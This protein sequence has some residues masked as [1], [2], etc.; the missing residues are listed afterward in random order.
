MRRRWHVIAELCNEYGLRTGAEIGVAEG[1]FTAALLSLCPKVQLW[2]IDDYAPGYRTWMGAEWSQERQ[3][4]NKRA[5]AEVLTQFPD[6][7]RLMGLSSLD[8][9][10]EFPDA[11]LDFVFIDAD[12]SYEAVS[13]DIA[14]WRR[15]IRPGGWMTGHD[16]DREKFPGVIRAVD[17]CFSPRVESDFVWMA[18]I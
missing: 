15:R 7:L 2:A 10:D 12:H 18:Q 1:R 4:A 5:F 8:A 6:R 17:E 14:V 9:A 16:Y 3:D 11:S 13:A